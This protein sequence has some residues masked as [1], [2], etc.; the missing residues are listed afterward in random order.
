MEIS[1]KE[2]AE[3]LMQIETLKQK[4]NGINPKTSIVDLITEKPIACVAKTQDTY[5]EFK[6]NNSQLTD[7]WKRFLYI[8]KA[9]H[10]KS[11]NFYMDKTI[12]GGSYI[13]CVGNHEYPKKV[14][15]M[16]KEEIQISVQMLDELI[17]IYNKYFKLTHPYVL[18]SDNKEGIYRKIYVEKN[19]EEQNTMY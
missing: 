8:A 18:Y 19:E 7:V 3:L 11:Y 10:S 14:T 13:R 1:E 16:T 5:P 15:D 2:Y 12:Y 6:Y 17:P 4:V 9:I